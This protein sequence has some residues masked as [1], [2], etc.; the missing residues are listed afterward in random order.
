MW[1]L[2]PPILAHKAHVTKQTT[3]PRQGSLRLAIVP[4]PLNTV[5]PPTEHLSEPPVNTLTKGLGFPQET[6][7]EEE[8]SQSMPIHQPPKYVP[9]PS[10]QTPRFITQ[11]ALSE[12]TTNVWSETL[13]FFSIRNWLI[14]SNMHRI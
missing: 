12:V 3:L 7:I 8:P 9:I 5:T 2:Q 6:V 1:N 4:G 11:E 13:T 14:S 10:F